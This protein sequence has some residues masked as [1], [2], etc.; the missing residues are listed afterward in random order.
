MKNE[1]HPNLKYCGYFYRLYAGSVSSQQIVD[2]SSDFVQQ[3]TKDP[4]FFM[5]IGVSDYELLCKVPDD[6]KSQLPT[7]EEIETELANMER[8]GNEAR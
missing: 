7:I 8:D 5:P 6:F 3:L 2:L 4:Y 1:R